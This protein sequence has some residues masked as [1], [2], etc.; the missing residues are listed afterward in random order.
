MVAAIQ[1]EQLGYHPIILEGQKSIGGR[2]Q[3]DIVEGF[4]LDRGFQVLLEAYPMAKKYL[5]YDALKL[6]KLDDGA[7]LF[8]SGRASTFGDPRRNSKF[9][10]PTLLSGH[11]T[12]ADKWKVFRL[13][14][15]LTK[16]QLPAI[17]EQPSLSTHDYLKAQGFSDKVVESF[18]KPFFNGI[19]LEPDLIT[20]SRMFEFVYKMFGEGSATIPLKGIG[21]IPAQLNRQLKQTT[22]HLGTKVRQVKGTE[23]LLENGETMKSDFTIVATNPDQIIPNYVSSLQWKSCEN[24]YFHCKSRAFSAPI[25]GLNTNTS[26]LVN[27]IF[28]P[29]SVK[30]ETQGNDELLSVTVVKAHALDNDTLA[31]RVQEELREHFNIETEGLIAHYKIPQAL[32]Q[33]EDLQYEREAAEHLL[34]EHIALAG[35]HILNGSLNAAMTSGENAA[36]AAHGALQRIPIKA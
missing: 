27:N 19:F 28:Y 22:F 15:R 26:A 23:I 1:L 10:L 13:N 29:T 35:D 8:S 5:N 7:L 6:Q 3:T 18:F 14:K 16:E 17:F 9:L 20:S 21:E 30:S 36:F 2:V 31:L 4:Q 33:L 11:A 12:L 25:I 32:P 24:L 34:T